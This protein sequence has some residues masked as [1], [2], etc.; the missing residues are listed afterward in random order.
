MVLNTKPKPPLLLG[1]K[2]DWGAIVRI[3][4]SNE[5][6]LEHALNL[7]LFLFKLERAH[8]VQRAMNRGHIILQI[9]IKLMPL[10]HWRKSKCEV[11]REDIIKLL[12][13][14]TNLRK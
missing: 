7:F 3:R 12:K 9:K 14:Y 8:L 1:Y 11:L 2:Q 4:W 10:A 6:V 13:D 5:A